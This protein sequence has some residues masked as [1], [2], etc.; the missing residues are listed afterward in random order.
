M[1]IHPVG[2]GR[3]ALGIKLEALECYYSFLCEPQFSFLQVGYNLPY[4]LLMT[5]VLLIL[6]S[7]VGLLIQEVPQESWC[8]EDE[9]P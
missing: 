6:K 1:F 7:C 3:G 2:V 9:S 5:G 4:W 8:Q